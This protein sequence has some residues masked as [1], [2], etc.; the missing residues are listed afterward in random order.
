MKIKEKPYINPKTC[1][2]CSVCAETCPMD[3]ITIEKP[4]FHGDIHTIAT[5]NDEHCI[6][7]GLCA[8][9]CPIYAIEMHRGG[10]ARV[11]MDKK[12]NL[13]T[14]FC[15]S[16]QFVMKIGMYI[17]PWGIPKTLKGPGAVKKLPATIKRKKFKKPLIVTDQMWVHLFM[18]ML[19]LLVCVIEWHIIQRK[20]IEG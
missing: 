16:F 11:I 15:R 6:G 14:L 10:E 8:K 20:P 1:A 18:L 13:E 17:L 4:K 5:V 3:C 19:I 7:C 9:V 12:L 2:G